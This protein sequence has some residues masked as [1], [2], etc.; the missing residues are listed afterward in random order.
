MR[1][2]KPSV[3][4]NLNGP[5]QFKIF[6]NSSKKQKRNK[7]NRKNNYYS[8]RLKSYYYQVYYVYHSVFKIREKYRQSGRITERWFDYIE[9]T[10]NYSKLEEAKKEMTKQINQSRIRVKNEKKSI[11]H[12]NNLDLT[13]TTFQV[14]IL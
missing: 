12:Q 11:H 10:S 3:K 13:T 6:K 5:K 4:L 1:Q 8:K 2:P 9:R 7:T 14:N